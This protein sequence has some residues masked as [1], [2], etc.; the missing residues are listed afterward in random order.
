MLLK[1]VHQGQRQELVAQVLAVVHWL[2]KKWLSYPAD[3]GITTLA[4]CW[5]TRSNFTPLKS[6]CNSPHRAP[7]KAACGSCLSEDT[8]ESVGCCLVPEKPHVFR[9]LLGKQAGIK[10]WYLLIWQFLS[11]ILCW[12]SL[13]LCHLAQ[14][15]SKTMV[16]T[17]QITRPVYLVSE[18]G[19]LP[20]PSQDLPDSCLYPWPL[21]PV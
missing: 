9:S 17:S 14:E 12:Q 5:W 1:C 7:G 10:T 21:G 11:R 19:I 8:G 16:I 2:T 4:L 6:I 13:T 15:V 20:S 18:E 3:D